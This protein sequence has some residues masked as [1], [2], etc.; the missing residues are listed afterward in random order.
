MRSRS[1]GPVARAHCAERAH[2]NAL[3]VFLGLNIFFLALS[4]SALAAHRP[5]VTTDVC[6]SALSSAS[7]PTFTSF[8]ETLLGTDEQVVAFFE[9][10]RKL[11][12][13]PS[14]TAIALGF[15]GKTH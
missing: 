1:F 9:R 11:E 5:P 14:E 3:R 15:L 13:S 2:H 7:F 8:M 12:F 6:A 10:A 4:G